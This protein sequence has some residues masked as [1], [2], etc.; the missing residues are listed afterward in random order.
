MK[1]ISISICLEVAVMGR[2]SSDARRNGETSSGLG[3]LS[4]TIEGFFDFDIDTIFVE[5]IRYLG[6][7]NKLFPVE[8]A[9]FIVYLH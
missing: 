1:F 7:L 5:D 9:M 6:V 2:F 3:L 4:C 8:I